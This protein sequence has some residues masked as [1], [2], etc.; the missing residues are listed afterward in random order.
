[1][2][3]QAEPDAID[4]GTQS[5]DYLSALVASFLGWTLDAFDFFLVVFVLPAIAQDFGVDGRRSRSRS[6]SRWRSGRSARSSSASWPTATAAA[7]R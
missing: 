4:P 6:R 7:C 2:P 1:M 3:R 5:D